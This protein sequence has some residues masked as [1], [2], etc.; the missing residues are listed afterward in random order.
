MEQ[1]IDELEQQGMQTRAEVGQM[2]EHMINKMFELLTRNTS[3]LAPA[4]TPGAASNAATQGIL[5]YPP[6]FSPQ[7]GM[8]LGWNTPAEAQV[9]EEPEAVGASRPVP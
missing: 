5:A 6:G 9:V 7:Y 2:R 3:L 1:A 4:I 8:P